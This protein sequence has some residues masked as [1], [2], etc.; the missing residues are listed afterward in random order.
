MSK[1][2][3]FFS[4]RAASCE[5]GQIIPWVAL[6]MV[7]FLGFAGLTLDLGHA[8]VCYRELQASTDAAALA[9]AYAMGLQGATQST[10]NSQV[11]AYS[12]VPGAVNA[13]PNLPNAAVSTSFR[14]VKDLPNVVQAPC[15]SVGT[16]NVI[17]VMQ[18]SSVPT[19]FIRAL[20]LFG[21]NSATT[22]NLRAYSTAT[23]MSGGNPRMNV[24]IVL[25]TTASM[26][27]YDTACGA[28]RI[29][30]ALNGVQTLLNQL[31]PCSTGSTSSNCAG[32]YDQVSLFTFPPVQANT[33]GNDTS[34]PSSN[35]AIVQYFAP[36]YNATWTNPSTSSNTGTYQVT[37]QAGSNNGF[38]DDY[39]TTN[40]QN[41]SIS[42]SSELGI[43]VGAGGCKGVQTP[44]GDGTYLAGSIFAAQSALMAA[45]A[46]NGGQNVM[47]V[48]SDGDANAQ[49]SKT[50]FANCPAGS[51]TPP[52]YTGTDTTNTS[53]TYPSI[54]DQCH[55]SVLAAN[56]ATNQGTAVYTIGYGA[57]TS[58]CSTD[59]GTI[60]PCTELQQ[61]SSNYGSSTNTGTY[62]YTDS[63]SNCP[64]ATTGSLNSVFG[65]IAAELSL[66]RLVPN[67]IT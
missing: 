41:G 63:T 55:Q 9:G 12:S 58:G 53:V 40:Q 34:C 13:T 67:G 57:S 32:A 17:Q 19:I 66:A 22:L 56:Y 47:I 23:G 7:L 8:Y 45:S 64:G 4:L 49:S 2:A 46:A 43:A 62:F 25:D 20:A 15:T 30:C 51:K 6:L 18:T 10:V 29:T 33:A 50:N 21:I 44:G 11:S 35:P 38:F 5:N 16:N 26:G 24:A 27:G 54:S 31:T 36:V 1:I 52:C 39:S 48:L 61:M 14:C 37:L 59:A 65:S 42:A 60:T 3:R 28:T